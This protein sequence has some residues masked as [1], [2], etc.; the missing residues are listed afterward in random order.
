MEQGAWYCVLDGSTGRRKHIYAGHVATG[1]L[2]C[3]S[4]TAKLQQSSVE[5]PSINSS[6]QPAYSMTVRLD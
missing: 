4:G 6:L 5:I 1:G 2:G 3:D